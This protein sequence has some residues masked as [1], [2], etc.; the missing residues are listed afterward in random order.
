MRGGQGRGKERPF[1]SLCCVR[2]CY[3]DRKNTEPCQTDWL[4]VW[5]S[6]FVTLVHLLNLLS[7]SILFCTVCS[8]VSVSFFKKKK[9]LFILNCGIANK[10]CCDSFSCD[11]SML[12]SKRT[13]PYIYMYP[14][15]AKLF[16]H[17][18][19]HITLSR[20]PCAIQ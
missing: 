17:P 19:C 10:Q 14:F 15:F 20:V 1:A 8:V 11:C 9:K 2:G 6:S 12:N 3:P 4:E 18:G 7:P 5:P 16:S 13:Q